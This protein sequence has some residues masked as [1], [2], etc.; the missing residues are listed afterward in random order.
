MWKFAQELALVEKMSML[1]PLYLS[2]YN[3]K[4]FRQT[5]TNNRG[6]LVVEKPLLLMTK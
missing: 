3:Q 1:N 4:V 2:Y 5:G 6:E